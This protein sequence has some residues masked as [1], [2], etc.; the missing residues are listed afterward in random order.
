MPVVEGVFRMKVEARR[1]RCRAVIECMPQRHFRRALLSENYIPVGSNAFMSLSF[2]HASSTTKREA[3]TLCG[4][5][6]LGYWQT[7]HRTAGA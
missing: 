5:H 2:I 4:L 6:R 3:H 1:R 7:S